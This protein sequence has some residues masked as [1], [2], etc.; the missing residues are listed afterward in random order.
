MAPGGGG[1]Q[2]QNDPERWW[3]SQPRE[4]RYQVVR[5]MA[6]E[7]LCDVTRVLKVRC[8]QCGGR[9]GTFTVGSSS[10]TGRLGG[11]TKV[12]GTCRGSGYF[13]KIKYR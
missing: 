3:M 10:Q 11:T 7:A 13:I 9:G 2:A 6:A 5:A 12:C 4:V 1:Q 8:T